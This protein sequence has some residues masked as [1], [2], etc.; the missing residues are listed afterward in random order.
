MTDIEMLHDMYR[1]EIDILTSKAELL[2]ELNGLNRIMKFVMEAAEN[3]PKIREDSLIRS[4]VTFI[5]DSVLELN[6][7]FKTQG[8]V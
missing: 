6:T 1:R 4:L 2:G 5:G 3:D 7:K 8:H